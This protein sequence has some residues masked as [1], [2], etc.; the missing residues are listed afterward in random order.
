MVT[1]AVV[2]TTAVLCG[3]VGDKLPGYT[4]FVPDER[5]QFGHTYG[6][7]HRSVIP[8]APSIP[9]CNRLPT[10]PRMI[11]VKEDKQLPGY[12]GFY[13]SSPRARGEITAEVATLRADGQFVPMRVFNRQL[14]T[15]D[16]Y[17]ER[18]SKSSIKLGAGEV[19]IMTPAG[20][21]K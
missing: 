13:P 6:H 1:T 10:S 15:N 17:A 4:G 5:A 14:R 18:L 19:S 2:V 11:G 20:N 12:T 8:H 9:W 21:F 16:A 7:T 3:S